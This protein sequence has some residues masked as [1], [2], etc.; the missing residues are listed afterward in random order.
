MTTTRESP[1]QVEG[2][3]RA[4]MPALAAVLQLNVQP[5]IAVGRRGASYDALVTN[6]G[7]RAIEVWPVV[8]DAGGA[9]VPRVVPSRVLLEPGRSI[10]FDVALRARR[11]RLARGELERTVALELR[12]ADGATLATSGL[13]FVQ[14]RT[15]VL[16]ALA[17]LV[18]LVA[19]TVALLGRVS[20]RV[21]VPAVEGAPDVA[22]AEGTL[23]AAGLQLDPRLRSRTSSEVA[24]GTI[25]GQIPDAGTRAQSGDRVTLLVA[26]SAKR[27]VTPALG[28][29]TPPRAAAVL[30]AAGLTLGPVLPAGSPPG[31]VI[32]SQLPAP[33]SRVPAGTAVT[34]FVRRGSGAAGD[35][36]PAGRA[37]VPAIDGRDVNA[38]VRAV[39]TAGLVPRVIRKV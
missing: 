10:T 33:G 3:T 23:N 31:A 1:A 6:R 19:V 30:R 21:T 14:Q 4:Q 39:A 26:I 9:L 5:S 7:P 35:A 12:D 36:A 18:V 34:L 28:G 27:S 24:P 2:A 22:T 8:G 38:Y 20:D 16:W 13:V 25:I 29:Q 11:P 17:L 32:D 37:K 15:P